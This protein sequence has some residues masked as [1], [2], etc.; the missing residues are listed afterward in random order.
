MF[1]TL[2]S[3]DR[4]IQNHRSASDALKREAEALLD[5]ARNH[6]KVAMELATAR[7]KLQAFEPSLPEQSG[8]TVAP[9]QRERR[10][11]LAWQVRQQAF[12]LI[13]AA[14]RPLSR[15]E[16]L[17]GL[18]DKGITIDAAKPLEAIGKIMWHAKEFENKDNKGYWIVGKP[19]S[20]G[21]QERKRFKTPKASI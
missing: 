14:G 12:D 20:S 8:Q 5:R 1:E 2:G 16:L 9:R 17:V 11:S 19:L 7:A 4:E 6:E 18:I 13:L 10:S 21:S 15:G 3:L